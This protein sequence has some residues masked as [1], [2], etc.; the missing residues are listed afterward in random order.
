[1]PLSKGQTTTS[2]VPITLYSSG[3]KLHNIQTFYRVCQETSSQDSQNIL[4]FLPL[5]DGSETQSSHSLTCMD[6]LRLPPCL[7]PLEPSTSATRQQPTLSKSTNQSDK[8][9][10]QSSLPGRPWLTL[11]PAHVQFPLSAITRKAKKKGA[12]R[13]R[14]PKQPQ[15][16]L[17]AGERGA[18]SDGHQ[19]VAELQSD[20]RKMENC[21]QSDNKAA[22]APRRRKR[23]RPGCPQEASSPLA[24]KHVRVSDGR[25]GQINLSGCSVSLS[26]NNVLAKER[27][28]ATSSSNVANKLKPDEPSTITKSQR[29]E[30]RQPVDLNTHPTRIRTRGFL[31]KTQETPSNSSIVL[32]PMARRAPIVQGF[33]KRRGRP[34][35]I[36]LEES[37]PESSPAM[38]GE[39]SHD[40]DGEQQ[41]DINLPNE[42]SVKR[43]RRIRKRRRNRSEVEE[44][45]LRKTKSAESTVGTE[46]GDNS[47]VIPAPRKL[48]TPKQPRM[49]TL[50]EFQKLIKRQHSKTR[51]SKEGQDKERSETVQDVGSEGEAC[52]SRCEE[53]TKEMEMDVDVAPPQITDVVE[54]SHDLFNV[55]VDE[56]HNQI[57]NKSTAEDGKSQPDETN[58]S[59]RKETSVIGEESQE[60]ISVDVSE[61]E[62]SMLAAEK[63]QPLNNLDGGKVVVFIVKVGR[64]K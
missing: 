49:V 15:K 4:E 32:K 10:P 43:K 29:E 24:C 27:E 8:I 19:N 26:S 16:H 5:T 37:R 45:P 3:Q 60:E 36:R 53:L 22:A 38:I 39:K 31:K 50:K 23:K 18:I 12:N 56:N 47:D 30:T 20:S 33:P 51:K 34:R 54:E 9:Q 64:F 35:K 59:T 2:A 55:T 41:T 1:M 25:K 13:S 46:A 44:I 58:G 21:K 57:F 48:R 7:S 28:M 11:N 61:E 6:D 63:E 17:E 42:E 14:R 62:E 40:V 52:G